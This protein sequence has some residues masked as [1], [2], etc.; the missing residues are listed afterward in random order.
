VAHPDDRF[1]ISAANTRPDRERV[2]IATSLLGLALV[3][4]GVAA[5]HVPPEDQALQNLVFGSVL[6]AVYAVTALSCRTF[7]FRVVSLG[8]CLLLLVTTG[9]WF[10]SLKHQF[11]FASMTAL[12]VGQG[13]CAGFAIM[14]R[15]E[16]QWIG[17]VTPT[18]VG[19][20]TQWMLFTYADPRIVKLTGIQPTASDSLMGSDTTFITA[21]AVATIVARWLTRNDAQRATP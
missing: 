7:D 20:S 3:L 15:Q 4:G 8:F 10:V 2:L 11:A 9:L 5:I 18:L 14:L 19:L 1:D 17:T 12:V 16:P 6:G 13:L 21:A